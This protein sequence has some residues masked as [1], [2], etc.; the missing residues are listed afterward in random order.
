MAAWHPYTSLPQVQQPSAKFPQRAAER[1]IKGYT[2]YLLLHGNGNVIGLSIE[3]LA[4]ELWG[5][6]V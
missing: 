4:V 1:S 6:Q 2:I 5:A 3:L